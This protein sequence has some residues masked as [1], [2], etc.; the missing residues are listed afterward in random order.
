MPIYRSADEDATRRLGRDLGQALERPAVILLRGE[1]GAGKT[2]LAKGLAQGLGVEDP[3]QVRSPTFSL[4]NVYPSPEGPVHHVDLYRLE[5]RRQ[6]YST[7]LEEIL[8]DPQAAVII[9]WSEKLLLP[10]T[11][12]LSIQIT[13]QDDD[14]RLLEVTRP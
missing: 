12:S 10:V 5:G 7:G 14:T 3:G 2:V 6:Q 4:I 11:P 13:S 1:L 8:A 9:E